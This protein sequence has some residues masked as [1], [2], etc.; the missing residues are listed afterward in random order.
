MTERSRLALA[1]ILTLAVAVAI[2]FLTLS[3]PAPTPSAPGPD[4][5]YH[6]LAFAA[7]VL[8]LSTVRPGWIPAAVAG[9]LFF[10]IAIEIVQPAFGRSF[11][12]A[13][14][15]ADAAGAVAGAALGRAL[16]ARRRAGR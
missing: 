15:A 16:S 9:A 12:L 11:E 2:G 10:G 1:L 4:K 7:L 5:L 3:P 13:D 14:M 6:A 8:P